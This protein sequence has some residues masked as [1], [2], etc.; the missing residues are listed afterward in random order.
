MLAVFGIFTG[1]RLKRSLSLLAELINWLNRYCFFQVLC[2]NADMY[3]KV[4][5]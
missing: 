2:R 4:S 1:A 3:A 5:H